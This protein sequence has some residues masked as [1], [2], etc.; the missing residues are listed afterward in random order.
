MKAKKIFENIKFERGQDPKH[1][2]RIGDK[3][4][5]SAEVTLIHNDNPKLFNKDEVDEKFWDN[6]LSHLD[7]KVT[8]DYIIEFYDPNGTMN[9]VGYKVKDLINWT[10]LSSYHPTLEYLYW[11][12]KYYKIPFNYNRDLLISSRLQE[13]LSFERGQDPINSMGIGL[14]SRFKNLN[15]EEAADII[16]FEMGEKL[17][18]FFKE[19]GS[20]LEKYDIEGIQGYDAYIW[21]PVSDDINEDKK[22]PE[23]EKKIGEIF[24]F[25]HEE[26]EKYP[27]RK[28]S[29]SKG[30]ISHKENIV[31]EIVSHYMTENG[32]PMNY[33]IKSISNSLDLSRINESMDFE[34]T[35]D[36]KRSM[37]IGREKLIKREFYSRKDAADWAIRNLELL[38]N[39]KYS[40]NDVIRKHNY[41]L[42]PDLEEMLLKWAIT[43]KQS[44]GSGIVYGKNI[45]YEIK[46]M[47]E[48]HGILIESNFERERDPKDSMGLGR[49][50]WA[51]GDRGYGDY[52]LRLLEPYNGSDLM[53]DEEVWK[54]K[55]LKSPHGKTGHTTYVVKYKPGERSYI[56]AGSKFWGEIDP[57]INNPNA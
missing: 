2:M 19:I 18:P 50:I 23:V 12:G 28:D 37:N 10:E 32:A 35:G 15:K 13:N 11:N 30:K 33:T 31:S 54:A 14:F 1:S 45:V 26:L 53:E 9:E 20:I 25:I 56:K 43:V 49:V 40:P 57:F 17:E 27:I 47:L 7:W 34:R 24:N 39:D 6:I 51:K 41:G 48:N 22:I 5:K 38:T 4:N 8:E 46:D 55:V 44:N 29:T 3:A 16:L 42:P 21:D 52:Q 36:P